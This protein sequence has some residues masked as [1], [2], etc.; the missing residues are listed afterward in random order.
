MLYG[1]V[2]DPQSCMGQYYMRSKSESVNSMLRRKM[3]AKIGK[4]LPQRK[5]TEESLKINMHNLRQS[6]LPGCTIPEMI[7]DYRGLYLK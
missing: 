2:E 1:L 6:L 4:K 5:R 7:K 3:S